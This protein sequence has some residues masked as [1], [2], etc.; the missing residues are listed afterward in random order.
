[1]VHPD[2]TGKGIATAL[3]KGVIQEARKRGIKRIEA[4]AALEN[5][6]SVNLAKRCGFKI[7]GKRKKGLLTDNWRY[8]DTYLFGK[9]LS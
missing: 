8:I 4:E 6:A 7:E 1:M 9:I 2:Y 3:L 5:K